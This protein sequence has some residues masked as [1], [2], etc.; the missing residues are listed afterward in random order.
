[1]VFGWYFIR[2]PIRIDK[3]DA[4]VWNHF[5]PETVP[6]LL[7][8]QTSKRLQYSFNNFLLLLK[9]FRYTGHLQRVPH[10]RLFA[11]F[12]HW[13]TFFNSCI[14]PVI[15]NFM[16]GKLWKFKHYIQF[17]MINGLFMSKRWFFFFKISFYVDSFRSHSCFCYI[18]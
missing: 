1:M 4:I 10:K 2:K 5:W 18:I 13:A 9:R 16:S 8:V 6:V 7:H 14:N 15:Y 17:V 12:A 3:M 11:L